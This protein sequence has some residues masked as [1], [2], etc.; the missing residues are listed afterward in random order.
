MQ[1]NDYSE[2]R[3]T[4]LI[5]I[6]LNGKTYQAIT[7]P[8]GAIV[9]AMTTVDFDPDLI[10]KFGTTGQLDQSKMTPEQVAGTIRATNN[11][12]KKQLRFLDTVLTPESGEQWRYYFQA[13]PKLE[14]DAVH[15]K[16]TI[17]DH[18]KHRISAAQMAAVVRDLVSLYSGRRP[19]EPSSSSSNG[20]GG[21][22][23]TS[24]ASARSKG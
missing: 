6:P 14:G 8:P 19:T 4:E 2:L 21:S 9:L 24:T 10:E 15:P 22:G 12:A 5:D 16:K 13:L 1:L 20:D 23:Q 17:D 11:Q 3:S 18:A 7:D